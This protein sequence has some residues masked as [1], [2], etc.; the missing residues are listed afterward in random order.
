MIIESPIL[1]EQPLVSVLVCTRNRA[2]MLGQALD[3]ILAQE[4]DFEF[5]ILI[6]EDF[7]SD[8]S[9]ALC[10]NYF[11]KY[12]D[13]IKL[14]L[15]DL[16]CGCGKNWALLVS[17]AKGKYLASCDDDDF[18]HT[19]NKLQ[20]QVDYMEQHPECGMVH[21]EWNLLNEINQK[22]VKNYIR[23]S[24]IIIPI[25]KIMRDIFTGK[26]PICISTS[27]TRKALIDKYVPLNDYIKLKFNIQDW[28]TWMIIS[29]YTEIH[30]LPISTTTYRLGHFSISNLKTWDELELKIATDRDMYLYICNMFPDDLSYVESGYEVY[31]LGIKL[32]AAYK[33]LDFCR[34]REYA[35]LLLDFGHTSL[36]VKAALNPVTFIV[37]GLIKRFKKYI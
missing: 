31:A 22:T 27:M 3:S 17:Q 4:C 13:K 34:A 11:N 35:Q 14:L 24:N 33:L 30:Y 15:H 23:T 8:N 29:K 25:G 18:W 2:Q 32:A 16:N 6:G 37:F 12:P 5:E 21:T 28:P 26:A 19:K 36:K 10:L 20:L 9:R 1:C 7:S